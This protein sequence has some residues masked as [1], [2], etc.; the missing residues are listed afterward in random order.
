M[1]RKV[2]ILGCL[3]LALCLT[4]ATPDING[5]VQNATSTAPPPSA[6]KIPGDVQLISPTEGAKIDCYYLDYSGGNAAFYFNV[7]GN[8]DLDPYDYHNMRFAPDPPHQGLNSVCSLTAVYVGVYPE[9]FIGEPDL[10][11]IIWDDG[12]DQYPGNELARVTIPYADLP[13]EM[14]YVAADVSSFDLTFPIGGEFHVGVSTGDNTPDAA[15]AI[16]ADDG[17]VGTGRHSV[18]AGYWTE[19]TNDYNFLISIDW[20]YSEEVPDT[21]S[22]G[23]SNDID[24]CRYT[25]NPDQIDTDG[26][27]IGEACDYMCGDATGDS[28]INIGDAVCDIEYIFKLGP[29]PSPIEAGD[30]NADGSVNVGDAVSLINYIFKGGPDP[31][32]PPYVSMIAEDLHCKSSDKGFETD[33]IP[34]DQECAFWEYDG[35]S[36]LQIHH[37]NAAFNCCP[38][39]QYAELGEFSNGVIYVQEQEILVEGVGCEC[40]CLFN[41]DFAI[42]R[43]PPGEYTIR[44]VRPGADPDGETILAFTVTLTDEPS[45]GSYCETRTGYPWGW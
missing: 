27:G 29:P 11:I 20:C 26:D 39:E 40:V 44:L 10:D 14:A 42:D 22:D 23:V 33:T 24:N 7:S 19:F 16:L 25:P 36:T 37:K 35:V 6:V 13:T 5:Q 45:S 43:L 1:F 8:P 15:I 30:A 17:T 2:S 18:W 9:G 3:I 32:C 21:D 31:A 4:A 34:L 28:T 38:I 12:I 41:I